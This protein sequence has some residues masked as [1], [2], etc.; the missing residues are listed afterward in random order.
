MYARLRSGK[1]Q[2]E[3]VPGNRVGTNRN[4]Q[5]RWWVFLLFFGDQDAIFAKKKLKMIFL[6]CFDALNWFW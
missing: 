5:G 2:I 3:A 1:S 6:D 4:G